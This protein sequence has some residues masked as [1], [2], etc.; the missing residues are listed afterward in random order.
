MT[1][2]KSRALVV[3]TTVF[4]KNDKDDFGTVI[5]KDWS[6]VTVKWDS[7]DSQKIM[8]NDMDGFT[9]A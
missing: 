3:G 6:S 7:R 1:G 4:W 8:H 2:E 5:A 9:A